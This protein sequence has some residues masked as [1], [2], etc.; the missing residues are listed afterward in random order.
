MNS[1]GTTTT[2]YAFQDPK[3]G[4]E[5]FHN[6][7][8]GST[9]WILPTSIDG[10]ESIMHHTISTSSKT[11]KQNQVDTSSKSPRHE[12]SGGWITVGMTC[13]FILVFNTLFLFALTYIYANNI[14]PRLTNDHMKIHSG[15]SEDILYEKKN[16]IMLTSP[17]SDNDDNYDDD[18]ETTMQKDEEVLAIEGT[19]DPPETQLMVDAQSYDAN[20]H[21]NVIEEQVQEHNRED[22]SFTVN[23]NEVNAEECSTVAIEEE[24]SLE[25]EEVIIED[26]SI[27][28]QTVDEEKVEELSP[29]EVII[30]NVSS[31]QTDSEEEDEELVSHETSEPVHEEKDKNVVEKQSNK[32]IDNIPGDDTSQPGG[33]ACMIPFSYI[34][35]RKCRSKA[36]EGMALALDN[37]SLWI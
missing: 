27:D 8:S 23:N 5:Y 3:S 29:H 11:S 12:Q 15:N 6:P 18:I 34:L 2:W 22:Y 16:E 33:G 4:R 17:S 20:M 32:I 14:G 1:A 35:V 26:V 30:E 9:S 37:N 28:E 19:P 10:S 21:M 24:K 7:Q 31:L 13:A 25:A 36:R